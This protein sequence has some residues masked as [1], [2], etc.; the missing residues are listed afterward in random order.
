MKPL[1]KIVKTQQEDAD[2]D[3]CADEAIIAD[4]DGCSYTYCIDNIFWYN[5]E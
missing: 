1:Y 3:E 2:G 4:I 5:Q